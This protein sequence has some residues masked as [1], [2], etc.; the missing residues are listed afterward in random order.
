[1]AQQGSRGRFQVGELLMNKDRATFSG[2][3]APVN[4]TSGTGVGIGGPGSLYFRLSN[5]AI[6]VNT[7]TKASPT[8]SQLGSVAALSSAHIFVGNGSN[9]G[10]DVAL[11]G[12]ATLANT[13]ALT[14]ASALIQHVQVPLTAV[15]I[16]ALKTTPIQVLAAPASGKYVLVHNCSI[17]MTY[18][19]VQFASGG[20]VSLVDHG[21]H[22]AVH[23][24]T[25]IA[26]ATFNA[27]ASFAYQLG[28]N[29]TNGGLTRPLATAV[30]VEAATGDFTTGDSTA[31]VDLWYSIVT[32]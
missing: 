16:K 8:W 20:V 22:N 7:N 18:G 23:T 4:G 12:D 1:M 25:G 24:A 10:T 13:G 11:S 6:Y 29:S 5:G 9:V 14:V 32:A 3:G 31:K 28:G 17:S 2:S 19:S 30:D 27:A 26:A 15:N 21:T